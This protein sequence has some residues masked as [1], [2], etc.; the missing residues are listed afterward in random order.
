MNVNGNVVVF[1]NE[2]EG[3]NGKFKSFCTKLGKDGKLYA[4]VRF[5]KEIPSDKLEVGKA[6]TLDME[7]GFLTNDVYNEKD[8]LTL[9]ITK[10]HVSKVSEVKAK[11]KEQALAD[12][13][14]KDLP[15]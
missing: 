2:K 15:F 6:Y 1:V 3:K 4:S 10:A 9:V 12:K 11:S 13:I 8:Y 7:E 5:S 14:D